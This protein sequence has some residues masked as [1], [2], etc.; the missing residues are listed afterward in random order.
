M[1]ARKT[2]G[3]NLRLTIDPGVDTDKLVRLLLLDGITI[4]LHR[5]ARHGHIR[6]GIE[7]PQ[8]IKISR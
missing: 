5:S 4:H 7:A 6:I 1:G 8:Q 2:K 3:E